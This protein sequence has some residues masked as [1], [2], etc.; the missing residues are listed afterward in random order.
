MTRVIITVC[1][2]LFVLYFK[3]ST[4]DASDLEQKRREGNPKYANLWFGPRIGRRK[5][6]PDEDVLGNM[7]NN[8]PRISL[9]FFKKNPWTI[10]LMSPGK[11]L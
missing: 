10:I 8:D 11:K 7:N 9:D 1:L 2:I 4:G 5:R 6:N 3:S